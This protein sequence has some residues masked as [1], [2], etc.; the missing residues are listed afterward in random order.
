MT[1]DPT[2]P[3]T[4]EDFDDTADNE[5]EATA[6]LDEETPEADA[7]EQHAELQPSE[8]DPLTRIDPAVANEADA[9][10]QTRVV[11]LDEDDYR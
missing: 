7:A 6:V 8:D 1:V 11:T 2:D 5:E 10:E 9:I 4:F 3:E